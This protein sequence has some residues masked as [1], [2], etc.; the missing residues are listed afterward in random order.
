M[1]Q[2]LKKKKIWIPLLI[3]AITVSIVA[4]KYFG[5]DDYLSVIAEKVQK[6]DIIHKINASGIIQP[7]EEVQILS[8]I[9]I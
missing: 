9:H 7:E 4:T 2:K 3:A 1:I 6:R 5:D 8:L